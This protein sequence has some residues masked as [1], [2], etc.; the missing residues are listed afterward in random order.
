LHGAAAQADPT[1]ASTVHYTV[2]FSE[3]VT[4]V[5]IGDFA[6]SGNG[7]TGIT[8]VTG[9]GSTY[10]VTVS[11]GASS[12]SIQLNLHDD[13]S[14]IDAA[15]NPLGGTGAG[16]GAAT[17]QVYTIDKSLNS[18]NPS[19]VGNANPSSVSENES[20]LLT[21][22]VTPGTNPPSTGL[23]V[24][25]DLSTI[26]GSANQAFFDNG[27]NGDVTGGDNV[28]TYAALVAPGTTLGGKS[29]PFIVQD[30]QPRSGGGTI[31]LT[32]VAA[33]APNP[34]ANL[35]ATA[36]NAQVSLTWDP[37]TGASAYNVR[38]GTLAGGPYTTIASGVPITNYL[39]SAVT[40]G[41]QYF[42]VVTATSGPAE[43]GPSNEASATPVA[44]I[45]KV[46]FIDI[47]QGASTLIVSPTGKTLLVDG[48]PTG[49]G[50]AKIV[51]LLNT[52]GINSIE[53]LPKISPLLTDGMDGFED[54]VAAR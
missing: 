15:T 25:G 16:N 20:T 21:V 7:D 43:S 35:V 36:G 27:T 17:G 29:L 28:F 14:I 38:R 53:E 33:N 52:L 50:N 19:G 39:D 31:S 41:T 2:T 6:L 45:G 49:Q 18:T 1:G 8:G 9:S 12:G 13:D 4:G 46:Y 3:S 47:G 44:S 48:G 23:T 40:N 42:Y 51:P 30:A 26:G 32:V 10:T 11:T 22:A 37:S 34:P 24:T 5:D 54:I